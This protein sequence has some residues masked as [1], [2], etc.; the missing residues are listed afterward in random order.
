MAL[1]CY[2]DYLQNGKGSSLGRAAPGVSKHL[3]GTYKC[4]KYISLSH[5]WAM[6]FFIA[7]EQDQSQYTFYDKQV[8]T[9]KTRKMKW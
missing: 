4:V 9:V 5:A 2:A 1:L 7:N 6:T 8:T 3:S